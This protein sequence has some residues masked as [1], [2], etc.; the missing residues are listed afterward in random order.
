MNEPQHHNQDKRRQGCVTMGSAHG[1]GRKEPEVT[2]QLSE[3]AQLVSASLSRSFPSASCLACPHPRLLPTEMERITG[4][5]LPVSPA[6]LHNTQSQST[7]T[8]WIKGFLIGFSWCFLLEDFS[9]LNCELAGVCLLVRVSLQSKEY[10][11]L[12]TLVSIC[13]ACRMKMWSQP[14]LFPPVTQ[15]DLTKVMLVTPT[16]KDRAH[17]WAF[18][19][20]ESS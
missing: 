12:Q 16:P 7:E 14:L 10:S 2:R 11:I 13:E 20:S 4:L 8:Y 3:Y 1:E 18:E 17:E 5:L 19:G 9:T 15:T 6:L